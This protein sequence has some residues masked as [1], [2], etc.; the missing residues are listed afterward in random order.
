MTVHLPNSTVPM[1]AAF[2]LLYA[3]AKSI[4]NHFTYITSKN[5]K[6]SPF[7]REEKAIYKRN[8]GSQVETMCQPRAIC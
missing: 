7:K 3:S 6:K 1:K 5:K 2:E 4:P 8:T